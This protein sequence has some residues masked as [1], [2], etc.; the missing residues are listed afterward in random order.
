MEGRTLVSSKK[1]GNFLRYFVVFSEYLNFKASE[2]CEDDVDE[3]ISHPRSKRR[4]PNDLSFLEDF[5]LQFPS[6]GEMILKKIDNQSLV[7]CKKVSWEMEG[8]IKSERHYWIRMMGR[9]LQNF[10]EFQDQ[11]KMVIKKTPIVILRKLSPTV[12]TFFYNDP[13]HYGQQWAPLHIAAQEGSL[14]LFK[15]ILDKTGDICS[16]RKNGWT[17]LHM[18]VDGRNFEVCKFLMNKMTDKN[19]G[20]LRKWTPLHMAAMVGSLNI[21]KLII[22]N[23]ENKNPADSNGRTPLHVAAR[24]NHL[25][26][27]KLLIENMSDKNPADRTGCTPLHYAA[28]GGSFKVCKLIMKNLRSFDCKLCVQMY[29]YTATDRK[30]LRYHYRTMHK[31]EKIPEVKNPADHNGVTPLHKAAKEGHMKICKMLLQNIIYKDPVDEDGNTPLKI[32]ARNNNLELIKL[33]LGVLP[34]A[35]YEQIE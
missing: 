2:D 33:L 27:C 20:S 31:G 29:T 18:A 17:T 34:T 32:A 30:S 23:I 15:Y 35:M 13:I 24:L 11:W 10:K 9:H 19:P 6:V 14:K 1:V 4:K 12:D 22:Q 5:C 7:N 25:E 16:K 28:E 3:G 26:I 8:F 21:S